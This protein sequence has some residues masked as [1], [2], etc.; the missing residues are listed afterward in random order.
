MADFELFAR[1]SK[2]VRIPVVNIDGAPVDLTNATITWRLAEWM[3]APVSILEKNRVPGDDS[4]IAIETPQGGTFP[5]QLVVKILKNEVTV[6]EG[7]YCHWAQVQYVDAADTIK[8]GTVSVRS[9]P[10]A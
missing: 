8:V 2:N 1:D 10:T 5:S 7:I 6:P 9:A 4:E 3:G